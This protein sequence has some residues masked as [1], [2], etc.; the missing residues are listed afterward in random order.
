MDFITSFMT[1][2][3]L[4]DSFAPELNNLELENNENDLII[5]DVINE[6]IKYTKEVDY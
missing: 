1:A 4:G 6:L 3:N 5:I 2:P